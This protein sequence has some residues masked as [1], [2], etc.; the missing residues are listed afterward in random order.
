MNILPINLKD[1]DVSYFLSRISIVNDCWIWS[2]GISSSGYGLYAKGIRRY[3]HRISYCIFNGEI[4]DRKVIDH[5]CRNTK[6]VNPEHIRLVSQFINVVENN[7]SPVNL[8]FNK[9]HCKNGH[10]LSD[11]NLIFTFRKKE[12]KEYR[13][14]RKCRDRLSKI[15]YE[16]NTEK[17]KSYAKE[18]YRKRIDSRPSDLSKEVPTSFV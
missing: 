17:R 8:N 4:S 13:V 14:C 12:N 15:N 6:C 7:I 5:L 1:I 16:K 10:V 18:Y 9:T 2:G 3:A 11:D